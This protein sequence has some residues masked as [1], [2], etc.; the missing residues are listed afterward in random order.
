MIRS[1]ERLLVIRRAAAV[2]FP[3]YWAPLSGKVEPGETSAAA[4]VREVAEEVGLQV[5][6]ERR[7]W[8]CDSA[9]GVTRLHWWLVAV[10]GGELR[11][12]PREVAE[13][14][15]IAAED[16]GGL[17]PIFESDREFFAEVWPTLSAQ[18]E[19]SQAPRRP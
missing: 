11:P 5:R 18:C 8:E 10:E 15:W 6:A 12:D 7:V 16:F 4:V 14:R 9:D 1:D 3:H 17:E 13:T 2:P 19:V